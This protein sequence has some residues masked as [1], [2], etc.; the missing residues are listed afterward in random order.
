MMPAVYWQTP[1]RSIAGHAQMIE[2]VVLDITPLGPTRGKFVLADV[3]VA[4]SRD[5]G[6]NDTQFFARTHLG[7]ILR[8]GDTA[9]GYGPPF[10]R[11]DTYANYTCCSYD[12]KNGNF[13]D[14]DITSMYGKE[15]PDVVCVVLC[16]CVVVVGR[17]ETKYF[18]IRSLCVRH[19]LKDDKSRTRA[20]GY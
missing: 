3:M 1:F 13:N 11:R 20:I 12:I 14:S 9:L 17:G 16:C 10:S 18:S 7:H 4:R 2:Y 15:L 6:N 5:L 8:A 19:I